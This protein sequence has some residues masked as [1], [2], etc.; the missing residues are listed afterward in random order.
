MDIPFVPSRRRGKRTLDTEEKYLD[1]LFDLTGDARLLVKNLLDILQKL[2]NKRTFHDYFYNDSL[3]ISLTNKIVVLLSK[4]LSFLRSRLGRIDTLY[5]KMEEVYES[6][7]REAGSISRVSSLI[8]FVGSS[9]NVIKSNIGQLS[10]EVDSLNSKYIALK[11]YKRKLDE[12]LY[13]ERSSLLFNIYSQLSSTHEEI[14][15]AIR[16]MKLIE[17][18]DKN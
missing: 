9:L 5:N 10:E 1:N 8:S 7:K 14:T 16:T 17:R 3:R 11:N 2:H 6:M 12:N 18:E 4:V 13:D 15:K